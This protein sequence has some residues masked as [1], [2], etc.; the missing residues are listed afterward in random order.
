MLT[1]SASGLDPEISPAYAELQIRRLAAA[2]GVTKEQISVILVRH[3]A[4]RAFGV[5]GGARLNVLE[6]G[7]DLQ[8]AYAA[9]GPS[10]RIRDWRFCRSSRSCIDDEAGRCRSEIMP[11]GTM[12][13]HL[14]YCGLCDGCPRPQLRQYLRICF[15]RATCLDVARIMPRNQFRP[16]GANKPG[17]VFLLAHETP[18]SLRRS[19]TRSYAAIGAIGT[20]PS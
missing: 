19:I 2:R 15:Q 14:E 10:N 16:L 4:G 6:L 8:S 1:T 18:R 20:K 13:E 9:A 17:S 12:A 7:L 5:F 11:A 3:V